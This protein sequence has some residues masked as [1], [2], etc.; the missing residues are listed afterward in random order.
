MWN[1]ELKTRLTD[2]VSHLR[3]N[4]RQILIIGVPFFLFSYFIQL[5]D[6]R[7]IHFLTREF[8]LK[9]HL[10]T[11]IGFRVQFDAEFPHQVMNF[12][13]EFQGY[14]YTRLSLF[15]SI[16]YS[17]ITLQSRKSKTREK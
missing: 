10:K 2:I 13:I 12:P 3:K 9:L 11:D 8:R 15:V 16:R 5:C 7:K 17:K 6:S 1:F 14:P 4:R